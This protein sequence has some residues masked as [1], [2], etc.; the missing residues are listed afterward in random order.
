MAGC[1]GVF[2][3]FRR[4]RMSQHH[5]PCH[6]PAINHRLLPLESPGPISAVRESWVLMAGRCGSSWFPRARGFFSSHLEKEPWCNV[7]SVPT[8]MI[9]DWPPLV[10]AGQGQR[11]QL[12]KV[13]GQE[14]Q[15]A[16]AEQV[17]DGAD[18]AVVDEADAQ[19]ALV[20]GVAQLVGEQQ[21]EVERGKLIDMLVGGIGGGLTIRKF[22]L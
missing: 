13:L 2:S 19:Q 20:A 18:G 8:V 7:H 12:G 16:L 5:T 17:L 11:H 3:R 15:S 9:V 21:G 10:Q 1:C 6:A 4:A 14:D 22:G